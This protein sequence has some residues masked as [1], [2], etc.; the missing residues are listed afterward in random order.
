MKDGYASLEERANPYRTGPPEF[1]EPKVMELWM[2]AK[3]ANFTEVELVSLKVRTV[4][5]HSKHQ[6]H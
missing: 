3:K 5:S 1:E 4:I 2:L 6:I